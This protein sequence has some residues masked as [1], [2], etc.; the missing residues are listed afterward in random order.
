MPNLTA[1]PVAAPDWPRPMMQLASVRAV[2]P[3]EGC[4]EC[5]DTSCRE[6]YAEAMAYDYRRFQRRTADPTA[7]PLADRIAAATARLYALG[8]TP[9]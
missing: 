7:P 1:P 4:D 8:I 5:S 3:S 9:W 6:C 2:E